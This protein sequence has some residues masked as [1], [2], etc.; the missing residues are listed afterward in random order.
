MTLYENACGLEVPP[1]DSSPLYSRGPYVFGPPNTE[2][3]ALL[4]FSRTDETVI[5]KR[6]HVCLQRRFSKS[7]AELRVFYSYQATVRNHAKLCNELGENAES[8]VAAYL[9]TYASVDNGDVPLAMTAA[10]RTD[11]DHPG[12]SFHKLGHWFPPAFP[13]ILATFVLQ[14]GHVATRRNHS[15]S[16]LR[17]QVWCEYPRQASVSTVTTSLPLSPARLT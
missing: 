14:L 5:R 13:C 8:L 1:K 10:S 2:K 3:D 6:K 7:A 12:P 17:C 15:A 16:S 4:S 11:I 9:C